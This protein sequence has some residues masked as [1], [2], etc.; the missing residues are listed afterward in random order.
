MQCLS[1]SRK[2]VINGELRGVV[3]AL[4]PWSRVLESIVSGVN[5]RPSSYFLVT[6]KEGMDPLSPLLHLSIYPF[7]HSSIHLSI[8]QFIHLS[9]HL[10]IH[11]LSSP[12]LGGLLY[13]SQFPDTVVVDVDSTTFEKTT[14]FSQIRNNIATTYV[15]PNIYHSIII[16]FIHL[17]FIL[18]IH[19]S[20]IHP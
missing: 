10:S 12:Y 14:E 7:I 4:L 6:K 19:L 15:H 11:P 1:L 18:F 5:V 2:W 9:I 20:F 8:Y 16:L 17:S 3:N 13:H